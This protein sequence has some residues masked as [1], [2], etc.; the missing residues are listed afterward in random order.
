MKGEPPSMMKFEI[1]LFTL[2]LLSSMYDTHK[3]G[4]EEGMCI[5]FEIRIMLFFL[6][7]SFFHIY[8]LRMLFFIYVLFFSFFTLFFSLFLLSNLFTHKMKF[9]VVRSCR[10]IENSNFYD[11]LHFISWKSRVHTKF[12]DGFSE[13]Q[14]ILTQRR[15]RARQSVQWTLTKLI[16][17]PRINVL[18]P[19]C[20]RSQ[21]ALH[22]HRHRNEYSKWKWK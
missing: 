22:H 18:I 3:V 15:E 7:I 13:Y 8:I 19:L 14:N 16:V 17:T 5:E 9:F 4:L 11:K 12:L 10:I 1:F 21:S 2:Q 20:H 6:R